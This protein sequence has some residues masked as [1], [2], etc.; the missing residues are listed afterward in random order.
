MKLVIQIPCYDEAENLPATLAALPKAVP[1]FDQVEVL[2]VDDGSKDATAAVARANGVRHV[3]RFPRHRGLARAFSA[4]IDAAVRLGADVVV[5]TD[6]DN[7]Y[8]AEDIPSLV[9]PILDGRA[10][11]VVGDRQIGKEDRFGAGKRVLQRFGSLVVRLASDTDLPDTTSGFRAISREAALRLFVVNDFTYT[12]ETIIQAG[13]GDWAVAHVPIRTN[14][15]TRSSRLFRSVPEYLRRSA[16]TILRIYTMYRPLRAFV[17]AAA[18]CFLAGLGL[19][20]RF[21]YFYLEDPGYSGHVQSLIVAA[22]LLIASFQL[23][24]SG[25]VADLIAANRKM[26]ADVLYRVRKMEA[27]REAA[28]EEKPSMD[29]DGHR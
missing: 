21:L 18:A 19:L 8:C 14:E 4:G 20:G 13:Q 15:Q 11:M 29:T 24:L 23:A 2:V 1:G 5:N 17:L 6:A 27:E 10:E 28:R 22:V 26:L 7:Q 12:L 3:V 25:I 9:A 16:G